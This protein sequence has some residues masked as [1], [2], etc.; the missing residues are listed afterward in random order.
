MASAKGLDRKL[1]VS[2]NVDVQV[3][4]TVALGVVRRVRG[5]PLL[6]SFQKLSST[7]LLPA[8]CLEDTEEAAQAAWYARYRLLLASDGAESPEELAK[9]GFALR[10][11][12][13]RVIEYNLEE[14]QDVMDHLAAIRKGGGYLNL[15]NDLVAVAEIYKSK[16]KA[17]SED[18]RHYTPG[19]QQKA[20]LLA[21]R[22]LAHMGHS[23]AGKTDWVDAQGR[24]W[25]LLQGAYDQVRRGGLFL[26][27]GTEEEQAFPPL[28]TAA[29]AQ[30]SS[31]SP[32]PPEPTPG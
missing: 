14:D 2:V 26:T 22:L 28:V 1:L 24:C 30:A 18:R 15:T 4:A 32:N 6:A 12:M 17:L 25:T 20:E 31:P 8:R 11:K 10:A 9:E 16:K 13:L 19:D 29:R 7:G 3:A 21:S 27:W 5:G 23:G